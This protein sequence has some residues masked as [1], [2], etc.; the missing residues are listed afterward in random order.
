MIVSG[1]LDGFG[2]QKL[3]RAAKL[4][5]ATI[6]IYFKDKEDLILQLYREESEK[7]ANE[8]LRNFDPSMS[9]SDGLRVQWMNRSKY[10][11]ENQNEMVFLEQIR[12]SS[13]HEKA[14]MFTNDVFKNTM[15]EFVVNAI[16]REELVKISVEVFW[17]IA[18]AP[19]YNLVRFHQ[20]GQSIGGRKFTFSEKIMMETLAIVLKGLKP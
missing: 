3:A 17:S 10:C 20:I 19:L 2:M 7:M 12:H 4:S 5:P 18:F 15:Q 13:L 11:M 14:T 16:K 9:F 6:Y 8:T 1:G